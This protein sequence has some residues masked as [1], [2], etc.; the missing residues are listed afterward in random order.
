[1]FSVISAR[2]R[3]DLVSEWKSRDHDEAQTSQHA[4]AKIRNESRVLKSRVLKMRRIAPQYPLETRYQIR[5]SARDGPWG[6][7]L[8]P[9]EVLLY[10]PKP[11]TELSVQTGQLRIC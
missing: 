3:M 11:E 6:I 9:V 2:A 5:L 4:N 10:P 8:P 1:V 7:V